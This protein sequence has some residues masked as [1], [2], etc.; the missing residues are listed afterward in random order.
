M[1]RSLLDGNRKPLHENFPAVIGSNIYIIKKT[2]A[3]RLEDAKR[4]PHIL[5]SVPLVKVHKHHRTADHIHRIIWDFL[6]A[7]R[8]QLNQLNIVQTRSPVRRLF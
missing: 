1:S 5:V 3:C 6:Q 4:F 2:P 8:T 7:N